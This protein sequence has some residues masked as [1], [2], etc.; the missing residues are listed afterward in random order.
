MKGRMKFAVDCML[1]KLAKWLKILGFDTLF[2][3]KI[4]DDD[5]LSLS[6]REGRI[7]LT[8]DTD[9]LKRADKARAVFV[10]S[11][12]WQEQLRQV[13]DTYQLRDQVRPFSRCLTC[14]TPLKSLPKKRAQNLV[15]PFVFQRARSFA[16]CPDCN[17][18]YWRGTH[19]RDMERKINGILGASKE[20]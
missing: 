1:G 14:N 19:F 20:D 2:F 11:E 8:R 3:P 16:L 13:L 7:L 6:L 4:D 18:V 12:K 10:Q 15:S 9:L 17:R 5:L